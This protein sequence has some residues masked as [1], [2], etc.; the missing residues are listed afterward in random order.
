MAACCALVLVRGVG[1]VVWNTGVL[2]TGGRQEAATPAG[3]GVGA[4]GRSGEGMGPARAGRGR[5]A[6]SARVK[7]IG[8]AATV[9][10]TP[11]I[12]NAIHNVLAPFGIRYIDIPL[13]PHEDLARCV[14]A[15]AY[16]PPTMKE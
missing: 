11:T 4:P 12:V 13:T 7:G 10:S 1:F 3:H 5:T 2:E 14:Q 16:G 15:L 6:Q 9:G 8:E